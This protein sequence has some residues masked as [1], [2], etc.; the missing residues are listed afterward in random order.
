MERCDKDSI[1]G[2]PLDVTLTRSL[3]QCHLASDELSKRDERDD[4]FWMPDGTVIIAAENHATSA[5]HLFRIHPSILS[6]QSPLF[7]QL[8]S[9]PVSEEDEVIDGCAVVQLTDEAMHVKKFLEVLYDP[10]ALPFE[11]YDPQTIQD[12]SGPLILAAKYGMDKLRDRIIQHLSRDWPST[13]EGFDQREA[14][15]AGNPR[16]DPA[17]LIHLIQNLE[18]HLPQETINKLLPA[19]L[20]E[21]LKT[22]WNDALYNGGG[23]VK[24]DL[25]DADNV[26]A[27]LVGRE[28]TRE[29]MKSFALYRVT[30]SAQEKER[31]IHRGVPST[32]STRGGCEESV[33]VYWME[34]VIPNALRDGLDDPLKFLVDTFIGQNA[35]LAMQADFEICASCC[36]VI[37]AKMRKERQRWWDCIL[38]DHMRS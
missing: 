20:Y 9:L 3:Q 24:V 18:D 32:G 8:F 2:G 38:S 19:A 27:C 36:E 22:S 31:C 25:L 1:E 29:R 30:I 17:E 26:R 33:A 34:V 14:Y 10:S 37:A 13:L 4:E 21:L 12:V 16:S 6:R 11:R 5:R 15:H 35:M 23:G 28:R 7:K